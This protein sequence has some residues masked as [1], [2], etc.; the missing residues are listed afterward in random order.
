[1]AQT[2][3]KQEIQ[4]DI[5]PT[6]IESAIVCSQFD[7]AKEVLEG[8]GYKIISLKECAQLRIQRGAN[9]PV[10]RKGNWVREG[11]IYVP[12]RG[13]FLTKFSPIMKNP[14]EATQSHRK[15][16]E[17]FL[18]E[19]QVEQALTDS[20]KLLGEAIPTKRFGENEITNYAFG[21]VAEQYGNFLH[22][23]GIKEM[24]VWL[25]NLE[26]K[27]FARQMWL[28]SLDHKSGFYND[29]MGLGD[30]YLLRGV[31]IK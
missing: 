14:R 31:K 29:G 26:D 6:G 3:T 13:I 4:V 23:T 28:G 21:E 11:V 7:K 15:G 9:S 25:A 22:E 18:T 24:P 27:P 30:N 8:K 19:E 2:R 10:S 1:M 16:R 20:V 5:R 12:K 17:Y